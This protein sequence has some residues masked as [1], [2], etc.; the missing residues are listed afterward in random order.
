[1]RLADYSCSWLIC[2]AR[3]K[4]TAPNVNY[5]GHTSTFFSQEFSLCVLN[6]LWNR[7]QK[8][9]NKMCQSEM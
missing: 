6:E 5:L 9:K 8:K 4:P 2:L 1:M 7:P 3:Y